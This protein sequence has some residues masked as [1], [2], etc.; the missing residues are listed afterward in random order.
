MNWLILFKNVDIMKDKEKLKN[1][2][3]VDHDK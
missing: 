3:R 1:Y 2:Y